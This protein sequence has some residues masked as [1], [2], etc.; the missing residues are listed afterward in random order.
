MVPSSARAVPHNYVCTEHVLLG[1]IDEGSNLAL[2]VLESLD[3][4]VADLRGELAAS[5]GPPALGGATR[6]ASVLAGLE[7]QAARAPDLVLI[8][9]GVRPLLDAALID[10]VLHGLRTHAAVLPA[11]PVTDTLKRSADGRVTRT[12]DRRTYHRKLAAK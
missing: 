10:R 1:V 11:L 7:A 2:K 12:I 5:M 6:Q 9:D 3:I 8:H 4:E